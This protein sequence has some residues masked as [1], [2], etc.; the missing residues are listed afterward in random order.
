M[1]Y[2]A[3]DEARNKLNWVATRDIEEMCADSWRH[4]SRNRRAD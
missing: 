3:A 4:A 2:A 1:L